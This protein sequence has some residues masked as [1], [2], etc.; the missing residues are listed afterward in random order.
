M[1]TPLPPAATV[2][3][4]PKMGDIRDT[5]EIGVEIGPDLIS[6]ALDGARGLGPRI[7]NLRLHIAR[8]LGVILPEVRI[9]DAPALDGG[10]PASRIYTVRT[11]DPATET[12]ELDV[13]VVPTD[14]VLEEGHRLRVDVYAGSVP[15]YL[16]TVPDLVKTR[17]GKQTVLL[18]PEQPSYVSLQIVGDPGW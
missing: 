13:D 16:A 11:F 8:S 5:D 15:R 6:G 2:D 18:S 9:T 3:L 1:P 12:I 14:A 10:E 17:F 7:N 4:R